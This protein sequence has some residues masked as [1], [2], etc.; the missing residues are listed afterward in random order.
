MGGKNKK[1]YPFQE[2]ELYQQ[3]INQLNEELNYY[4]K[5]INN[6]Y[7]I[8]WEVDLKGNFIF[9]NNSVKR[10]LGY[11][12]RDWLNHNYQEF[13]HPEDKERA[14]KDFQSLLSGERI[15][16]SFEYR[17]LSK[18]GGVKWLSLTSKRAFNAFGEVIGLK[19]IARDITEKKLLEQE[20]AKYYQNLEKIIAEKTK[21]LKAK[22]EE[23]ET[24]AYTVSHDL[25]T[26]LISLL[27][28]LTLMIEEYSPILDSKALHYLN[29]IQVNAT[30]MEKLISDLLEICRIGKDD[31]S[32]TEIDLNKMVNRVLGLFS[33]DI[34]EK[35]IH[36]KIQPYLGKINFNVYRIEQIFSNLISNA[37]RFMGDQKKPCIEIGSVDRGSTLE[38]F[39]R[40]NG[41]GIDPKDQIRIFNLFEYIG[42]NGEQRGSGIGL[43]IV[44]RI[45]E[46]NGGKIWVESQPGIG[47]TF[48]FSLPKSLIN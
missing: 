24:F 38:I 17:Y 40:D 25:K 45:V 14:N 33:K 29:R 22:N 10:I 48:Y 37:I 15:K 20:L 31:T 6:I 9:I 42:G 18:S 19:G 30:K 36:I 41:I 35:N 39:V 32:R 7:D 8:I 13:I 44:K 46:N 27:G 26:P 28:F 34:E 2:K 47:S 11:E 43:A 23:L 5:L 4:K 12:P 1:P 21:E 16:S 3:K